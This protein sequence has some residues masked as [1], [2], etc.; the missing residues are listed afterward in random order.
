MGMVSSVWI[1]LASC[2]LRDW[3]FNPIIPSDV[4]L[5][6]I[7]DEDFSPGCEGNDKAQWI[8]LACQGF[9]NF[10]QGWLMVVCWTELKAWGFNETV[11]LEAQG[12]LLEVVTVL[13]Q[14]KLTVL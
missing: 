9:I 11:P 3:G 1:T 10:P 4:L 12:R 13:R 6:D 14:S 7:L 8:M 2:F 5:P